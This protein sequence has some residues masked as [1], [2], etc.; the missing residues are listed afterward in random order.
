M[1]TL[2]LILFIATSCLLL[3]CKSKKAASGSE[4]KS[5]VT[6]DAVEGLNLGNKAPDIEMANPKGEIIKLSSLKGKV[7]LI[8]FWA[9]WCGPC[10]LENPTVVQAYN[11]YHTVKFKEGNGFEVFGVSLDSNKDSWI[12]AIDKDHLVWPY[13]VSDLQFWNNAAAKQYGVSS[14]P[15][16]V[17]INGKGIIVAKN[18][19]GEALHNALEQLK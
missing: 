11:T 1:K 17:L 2:S 14:I 9:S 10:R 8:D 4:T 3:S 12:K 18:L 15:T 13:H 5:V 6:V 16:N 7:V 19:R